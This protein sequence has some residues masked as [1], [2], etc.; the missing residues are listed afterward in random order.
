MNKIDD[1][2]PDKRGIYT[3]SVDLNKLAK[4]R[5]I[6]PM[7]IIQFPDYYLE[8]P[9]RFYTGGW[10][11]LSS[12][13]ID[14]YVEKL[15][16]MDNC[17]S[18]TRQTVLE[19]IFVRDALIMHYYYLSMASKVPYCTIEQLTMRLHSIDRRGLE[20]IFADKTH[21]HSLFRAILVHVSRR[22]H[23]QSRKEIYSIG[24]DLDGTI[25]AIQSMFKQEEIDNINN[26]FKIGE[27]GVAPFI[28]ASYIADQLS[29]AEQVLIELMVSKEPAMNIRKLT[30][31]VLTGHRA[32]D[33]SEEACKLGAETHLIIER[34]K[35]KIK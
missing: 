26:A 1:P 33:F 15:R 17:S 29:S 14:I 35:G 4:E 7:D 6:I 9:E 23:A 21:E 16:Q 30:R 20:N 5:G 32:M 2:E 13:S 19:R 10:R 28:Q 27:D 22:H 34:A 18:A 11:F 24:L 8:N 12:F 25:K 3:Y 31:D